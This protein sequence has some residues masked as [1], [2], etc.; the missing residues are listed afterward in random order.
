MIICLSTLRNHAFFPPLQHTG[1][2]EEISKWKLHLDFKI[3]IWTN[4]GQM[5]YVWEFALTLS[6]Y[7][8]SIS[9]LIFTLFI[10][11]PAFFC[12]K[13][14]QILTFK[15]CFKFPTWSTCSP[16]ATFR[17][18]SSSTML[19]SLQTSTLNLTRASAFAV[20]KTFS[21]PSKCFW[22]ELCTDG[23]E[24]NKKTV[25]LPLMFPALLTLRW[26]SKAKFWQLSCTASTDLH[27]DE[28]QLWPS[29][30]G[31]ETDLGAWTRWWLN[32]V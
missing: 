26:I 31:M 2:Q 13:S 21:K 30:M 20:T 18:P 8:S 25:W 16:K 22:G 23:G 14:I 32:W 10:W 24:E 5:T 1:K 3:L 19:K 29:S 27:F 4:W 15:E 28:W 6:T 11:R 7:C 9:I 17:V 12:W